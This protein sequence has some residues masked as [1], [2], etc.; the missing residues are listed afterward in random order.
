MGVTTW[1]DEVPINKCLSFWY[2]HHTVLI[3]HLTG[4]NLE[5]Q[6]KLQKDSLLNLY[7]VLL[8]K[9]PNFHHSWKFLASKA[10]SI[11]LHSSC[12]LLGEEVLLIIPL[13]ICFRSLHF[14]LLQSPSV[15]LCD[16]FHTTL[17][18]TVTY[19]HTHI[20]SFPLGQH[21]ADKR[22]SPPAPPPS[23]HSNIP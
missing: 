10:K 14:N 19:S 1:K 16:L 21:S 8:S 13:V 5:M 12:D 15:I 23:T 7:H 6:L 17:A 20:V 3:N 22:C 4:K 2:G 9:G 18:C 11:H